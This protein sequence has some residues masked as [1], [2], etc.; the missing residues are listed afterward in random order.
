ME[1]SAVG[2]WDWTTCIHDFTGLLLILLSAFK[3]ADLK[4]FAVGF[5]TYD[6]L[7]KFFRPYAYLYP[8]L[9]LALGLGFLAG[10]YLTFVSAATAGIMIFGSVGLF[11]GLRKEPVVEYPSPQTAA[12][13]VLSPAALVANLSIAAMAIL[14]GWFGQA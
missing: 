8:L 11:I 9:E 13:G 14:I 12:Q 2:S 3:L 4:A 10:R 6:L 1:L 7:A 5:S